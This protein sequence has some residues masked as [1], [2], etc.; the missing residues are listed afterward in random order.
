MNIQANENGNNQVIAT[1]IGKS[2]GN[3]R[4]IKNFSTVAKL[5]KFQILNLTKFKKLDMVKAKKLNFA[6]FEMS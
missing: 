3:R 6:K 4:D 5:T 2:D 1:N